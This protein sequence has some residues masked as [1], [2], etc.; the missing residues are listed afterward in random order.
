MLFK[1]SY[2]IFFSITWANFN[3]F[4]SVFCFP[5]SFLFTS[6]CCVYK[7]CLKNMFTDVMQTYTS[8]RSR[9]WSAT[10]RK[11]QAFRYNTAIFNSPKLRILRSSVVISQSCRQIP[12][13]CAN[14]SIRLKH[15]ISQLRKPESEQ[16]P[17]WKSQKGTKVSMFNNV[18]PHSLVNGRQCSGEA[19]CLQLL[20]LGQGK[21]PL[22]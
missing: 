18:T 6:K 5:Q 13:F 22:C 1:G 21:R 3:F 10:R 14:I 17:P 19:C 16:L 2:P 7:H 15:N 20:D 11:H 4:I 8:K 12:K 9:I